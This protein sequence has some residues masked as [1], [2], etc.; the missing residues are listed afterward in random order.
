MAKDAIGNF[1]AEKFEPALG[2]A[3]VPKAGDGL[4]GEREALRS[5]PAGGLRLRPC[6]ISDCLSAWEPHDQVETG[7]KPGFNQVEL[8][9]GNFVIGVG[10]PDDRSGRKLDRHSHAAAFS[11][12]LTIPD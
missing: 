10:I 2:I 9:D 6:R 3:D 1:P 12:P 7:A 11:Q 8:R 5:D 4:H